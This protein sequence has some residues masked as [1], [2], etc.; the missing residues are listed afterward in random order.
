MVSKIALRNVV[1]S[2]AVAVPEIFYGAWLWSC[3]QP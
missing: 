3:D 2:L 1:E